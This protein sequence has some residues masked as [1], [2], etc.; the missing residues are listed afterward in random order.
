MKCVILSGLVA[1]L[2]TSCQSVKT[3]VTETRS[4]I[5]E[6]NFQIWLK[7]NDP[8]DKRIAQKKDAL[9]CPQD[10]GH[11]TDQSPMMFEVD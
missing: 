4:T 3:E 7:N 9:T 10:D 1:V 2:S 5:H 6:R 8:S 11:M